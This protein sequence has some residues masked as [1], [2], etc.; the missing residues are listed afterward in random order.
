[1]H[2]R[3]RWLVVRKEGCDVLVVVLVVV[4][5]RGDRAKSQDRLAGKK[6][7]SQS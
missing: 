5:L 4:L 6:Q 1:M 3:A 7:G 2:V